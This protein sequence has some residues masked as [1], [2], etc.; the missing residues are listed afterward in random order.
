MADILPHQNPVSGPLSFR[1]MYNVEYRPGEDE[2]INYR[3]QRR[4]RMESVNPCPK[5]GDECECGPDCN[6]GSECECCGIVSENKLM[7]FKQ[8]FS[9][10]KNY[11]YSSAFFVNDKTDTFE[12]IMKGG[13]EGVD[14]T[15][16]ADYL[17][18]KTGKD[19]DKLYMD[20]SDLVWGAKTI[21]K[22]WHK[23]PI[24][25]LLDIVKKQ[26]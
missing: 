19:R 1:H 12:K 13:R 7:R 11:Q 21:A 26:R 15:D 5:C 3:V 16:L 6:C 9:E 20:G 8:F 14:E 23:T 10:A 17:A 22:R 24:S 18:Q 4:K 2:S 25:K